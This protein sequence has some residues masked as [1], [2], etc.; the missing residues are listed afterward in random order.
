M[1][2]LQSHKGKRG[3]KYNLA[4]V[5][6]D[7]HPG[8]S[9]KE[10][11]MWKRHPNCPSLNISNSLPVAVKHQNLFFSAFETSAKPRDYKYSWW[12]PQKSTLS[13]STMGEATH[14][15]QGK[16][17]ENTK[18]RE[19]KVV[20]EENSLPLAEWMQTNVTESLTGSFFFFMLKGTRGFL[21]RLFTTSRFSVCLLV[22]R[23]PRWDKEYCSLRVTKFC[24][25]W[26]SAL[27]NK[28]IRNANTATL[29]TE[30]IW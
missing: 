13:L 25:L 28:K 21:K 5:V 10:E 16:E 1:A 9:I 29:T 24:L 7:P 4:S 15:A 3:Q 26:G 23:Q 20:G 14:L 11:H 30:V 19:A 22:L 17:M 18:E 27:N 2:A 8:L 6:P 12:F